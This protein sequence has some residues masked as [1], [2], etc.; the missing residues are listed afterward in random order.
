[1][2]GIEVVGIGGRERPAAES[3]ELGMGDHTGDEKL[4]EPAAAM[5]RLD[6]DVAEVG[7][8]RAVG[9]NSRKPGLLTGGGI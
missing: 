3:L 5:G 2:P 6:V 1:M 7:V 8:G 9:H 4:A